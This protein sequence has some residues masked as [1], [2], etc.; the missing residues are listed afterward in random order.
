VGDHV[1][2][3]VVKLGDL[4]TLTD[5]LDAHSGMPFVVVSGPTSDGRIQLSYCGSSRWYVPRWYRTTQVTDEIPN[6]ARLARARKLLAELKPDPDGFKRISVG[7]HGQVHQVV[8]GH[9]TLDDGG[10]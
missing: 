7:R 2:E 3:G 8:V 10:Q 9:V 5:R 6:S 4:V 1:Q